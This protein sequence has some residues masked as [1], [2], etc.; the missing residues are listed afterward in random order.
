M[1]RDQERKELNSDYVSG[2]DMVFVELQLVVRRLQRIERLIGA[3]AMGPVGE[4]DGVRGHCELALASAHAAAGCVPEAMPEVERAPRTLKVR[5]L[6][7]DRAAHRAWF[8][9]RELTL[10]A[11]EFS[12]LGTLAIDPLRVHSRAELLESVWNFRAPGRTRTVDSHAGRLR[13]KLHE[14]GAPPREWVV[15]QWGVGYALLR[16]DARAGEAP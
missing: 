3:A 15:N 14:A 1:E 10:S 5:D 16:A 8:G 11:L 6:E 12:L 13:R 2:G 4:W 9:R 7:V